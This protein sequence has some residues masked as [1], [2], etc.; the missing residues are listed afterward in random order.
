MQR[1]MSL[2]LKPRSHQPQVLRSALSYMNSLFV[3]SVSQ[4]RMLCKHVN[5]VD[6]T[7]NV[8]NYNEYVTNY[9]PFRRILKNTLM[10][11]LDVEGK[12]I[13]NIVEKYPQI[14]KRSRANIL[15]NYYNLIEA[16]VQKNT[17]TNN[18]WLLAHE[19]NKLVDKL[20]CIKNLNMDNNQLIPWLRLTH[21]EL[22][23]YVLYTQQDMNSYNYNKMDY[24]AYKL[25]VQVKLI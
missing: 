25:E 11:I 12:E 6:H 8:S 18:A 10:E 4:S 23:N 7:C 2:L 1:V 24:L 13:T 5:V 17:I 20:D 9:K 21:G 3:T 16:G 19:N 22:A 14:K 15:N